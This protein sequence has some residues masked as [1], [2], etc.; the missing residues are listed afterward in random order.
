[1]EKEDGRRILLTVRIENSLGLMEAELLIFT[2]R[3]TGALWASKAQKKD[4]V[5]TVGK[6]RKE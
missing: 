1:M 6:K 3:K 5:E 4:G 2:A